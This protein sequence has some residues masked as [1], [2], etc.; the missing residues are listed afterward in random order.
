[1]ECACEVAADVEASCVRVEDVVVEAS[2]R[3]CLLAL[4]AVLLELVL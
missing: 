4:L 3:L 1:M 2:A